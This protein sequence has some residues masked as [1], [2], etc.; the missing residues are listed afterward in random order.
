MGAYNFRAQFE[1]AIVGGRKRHTIRAPRKVCRDCTTRKRLE[2]ELQ[3]ARKQIDVPIR[4]G[5]PVT[6]KHGEEYLRWRQENGYEPHLAKHLNILFEELQTLRWAI[7]AND[8][9]IM[10]FGSEVNDR[11]AEIQRLREFEARAEAMIG[12]DANDALARRDKIRKLEGA[13]EVWREIK[14]QLEVVGEVDTFIRVVAFTRLREMQ[15]QE[16]LS[17]ARAGK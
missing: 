5:E 10:E 1:D 15:H 12:I 11:G 6:L 4:Q 7:S 8:K 2:G 9:Q 17:L 16:E 3:E 13:L 14:L